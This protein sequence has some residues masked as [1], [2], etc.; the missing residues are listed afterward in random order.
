MQIKSATLLVR[1]AA[2]ESSSY[3]IEFPFSRPE[4]EEILVLRIK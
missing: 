3:K 2:S 1:S 4:A